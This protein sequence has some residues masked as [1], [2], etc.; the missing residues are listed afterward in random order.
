MLY[1]IFLGMSDM[2]ELIRPYGFK[3]YETLNCA[4]LVKPGSF[5]KVREAVVNGK[6]KKAV[7]YEEDVMV[8]DAT[9]PT[10][11]YMPAHEVY[12]HALLFLHMPKVRL[13]FK[14]YYW[15]FVLGYN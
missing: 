8:Y 4:L 14:H 15:S 1:H 2:A 13:V 7:H 3:C 6:L 10:L 11:F 9:T 5:A 12:G